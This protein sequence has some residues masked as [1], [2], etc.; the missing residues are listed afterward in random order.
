[1]DPSGIRTPEGVRPPGPVI[2]ICHASPP[3]ELSSTVTTH[4]TD[5]SDSDD[6]VGL[7]PLEDGDGDVPKPKLLLDWLVSQRGSLRA[8]LGAFNEFKVAGFG[9]HRQT[10][11][12]SAGGSMSMRVAAGEEED[13]GDASRR[14]VSSR[15][16]SPEDMSPTQQAFKDDIERGSP[17]SGEDAY[18]TTGAMSL[19]EIAQADTNVPSGLQQAPR[20]GDSEPADYEK[21]GHGEAKDDDSEHESEEISPHTKQPPRKAKGDGKKPKTAHKSAREKPTVGPEDEKLARA[22]DRIDNRELTKAL[23]LLMAQRLPEARKMIWK[24]D[25]LSTLHRNDSTVDPNYFDRKLSVEE[26]LARA[27][28]IGRRE[29]LISEIFDDAD[30]IDIQEEMPLGQPNEHPPGTDNP[31]V[32]MSSISIIQDNKTWKKAVTFEAPIQKAEKPNEI[33]IPRDADVMNME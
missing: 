1:M 28:L 5:L 31:A 26:V 20:L 6:E 23:L 30:T 19:E 18:M 15:D 12:A 11:V 8:K 16:K 13:K 24:A 2:T 14:E 17:E 25:R 9:D 27:I 4:Q 29:S 33:T 10:T 7:E 21:T 32:D 3:P 22:I